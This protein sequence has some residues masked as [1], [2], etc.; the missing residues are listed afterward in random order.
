MVYL[1]Q[2]L[3]LLMY[4]LK[5]RYFKCI[6]IVINNTVPLYLRPSIPLSGRVFL[7][8]SEP[9][10]SNYM[11]VYEFHTKQLCVVAPTL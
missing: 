1:W 11:H 10:E 4:L 5:L 3:I 8:H 7:H 9:S 6:Y 2:I